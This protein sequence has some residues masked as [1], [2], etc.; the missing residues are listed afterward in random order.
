[1]HV[2]LIDTLKLTVI[3]YNGDIF[4]TSKQ[5]VSEHGC[6]GRWVCPCDPQSIAISSHKFLPR[7][8]NRRLSMERRYIV[9]TRNLSCHVIII[10]E[11]LRA[12]IAMYIDE[13]MFCN[14]LTAAGR[15]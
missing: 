8:G 13:N 11:R 10:F 9:D 3:S 2:R 5:H 1:M 12:P 15:V 4:S 14:K 6:K 7:R